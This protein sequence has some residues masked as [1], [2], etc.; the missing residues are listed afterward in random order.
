M[1]EW[2]LEFFQCFERKIENSIE[3]LKT[4]TGHSGFKMNDFIIKFQDQ[5]YFNL[6]KK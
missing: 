2:T 6:Q 3:K 1:N 4:E 5:I